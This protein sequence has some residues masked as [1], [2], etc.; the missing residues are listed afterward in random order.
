MRHGWG[1]SHP[2]VRMGNE[3]ECR[4]RGSSGRGLGSREGCMERRVRGVRVGSW[5]E[6]RGVFHFIPLGPG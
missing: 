1:T 5:M 6:Y 4:F 2:Q 3:A